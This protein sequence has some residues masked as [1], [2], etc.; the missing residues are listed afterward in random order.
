MQARLRR[1]GVVKGTRQLKPAPRL[2]T[3]STERSS[4]DEAN[5][6]HPS[7]AAEGAAPIGT[8][9]PLGRV[10]STPL[11]EC[12]VLDSVYPLSHR[13]G[14][15]RLHRLTQLS[16]APAAHIFRDERL[17]ELDSR[18][19]LF[20]DTETT[21]LTGAGTIAFMVGVAFFQSANPE[22][23]WVV[24]QYFL[25]DHGDEPA[26]LWL[27]NQLVAEKAALVT[28]NGRSFDLP[29]LDNRYLL[30]RLHSNLLEMPHLDLLPPS[31]RLWRS[32]LVS[33]ALSS[34]ERHLLGVQRT[35]AD[36]PGWLI[37]GLYHDYLRS[38]DARELLRVFYHNEVDMLSMLTLASRVLKIF[39]STGS[40]ED[41]TDLLSL[42]RWQLDLGLTTQS[43]R[44]L[45]A[46]ASGDLPLEQFHQAL[47]TLALLLKRDSRREEAVI[48]WQQIAATSFDS[49]DAHVELA[50]HF[51]WQHQDLAVAREW[52]ERA[53]ALVAS[54]NA[55]DQRSAAEADLRHRLE[56][57][58]RKQAQLEE[59]SA[60]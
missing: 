39:S 58:Q 51:E 30:N 47:S 44:T 55:G 2:E 12:F 13:H 33:C 10:E 42:G 50:K 29:L 53:L 5:A 32:R 8:L 48:L 28:F 57:L 15:D 27:L 3:P 14:N 31:R 41:P 26:M 40:G 17:R 19:F 49:V 1:L 9:L 18:D 22:D 35:Q 37:P 43:E 60:G 21:G 6:A 23:Q 20:L 4:R 24:R 11:G 25:R 46:A 36:V 52:T 34:L 16:I 54:W 56:R 38:G 7:F 59:G 45:R